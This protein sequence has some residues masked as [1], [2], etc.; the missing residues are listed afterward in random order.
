MPRPVH[1]E[2]HATDPQRVATFYEQAF[3]WK[4]EQWG[5]QP[6]W[7]ITT[8]DTNPGIDGGI[9]PRPGPAPAADAPVS[10]FVN[11]IDVPDLDATRAAINDAG[12]TIALDKHAVPGVGWLAYFKDPDGN[13]F[14]AMQPDDRAK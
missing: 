13:V 4:I 2:I 14:G 3:G 8:G 1:F 12:G 7:L 10:S 9:V 11:T 5:D 6:Y